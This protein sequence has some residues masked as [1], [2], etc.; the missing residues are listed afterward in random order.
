M[1][2]YAAQ[3]TGVLEFTLQEA[4]NI[5]DVQSEASLA[6]AELVKTVGRLAATTRVE[7]E[8]INGSAHLIKERLEQHVENASQP[9]RWWLIK[10]L[11][12]INGGKCLVHRTSDSVSQ[13]FF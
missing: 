6:A 10:S 9:W 4:E 12:L 13:A 5:R 8:A 1:S 11:E 2:A 7:L 3:T